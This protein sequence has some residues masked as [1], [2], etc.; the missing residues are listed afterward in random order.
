MYFDETTREVFLYQDIGPAWAGMFDAEMM[1]FAL[2]KL[3]TGDINL[4]VNSYGGSVDEA[5][6]MVEILGRHNGKVKVTVDSIAASA[7]SLFPVVFE[8][9]AAKHARI[10]IHDPWSIAI[11][12]AT[13][14]RKVADVLDLYRDSIL[15]I[16][17]AGMK[18]SDEEIKEMMAAE[19]WFSADDAMA[20]GLVD[21]V[22][23]PA[24]KV[25]AKPAPEN[26]G[27]KNLPADLLKK[28][29]PQMKTEQRFDNRIAASLALLKRKLKK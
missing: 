17:K 26:R 6:G 3:G 28:P 20:N 14:M 16:Y 19:T 1:S 4:R 5:M 8:S 10:M 2:K 9:T 29:E 15:T 21:A 7:A 12:N 27:F 24:K 22:T 25:D 13:A 18:K 11:G 23:E